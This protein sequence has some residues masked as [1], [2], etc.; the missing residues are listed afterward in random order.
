MLLLLFSNIYL[1]MTLHQHLE[2]FFLQLISM[3]ALSHI[4]WMYRSLSN[5]S[6]IMDSGLFPVFRYWK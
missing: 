6:P 5:Q 3:D 1:E 4:E 2:I